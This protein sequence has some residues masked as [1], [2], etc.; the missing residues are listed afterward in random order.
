[1]RIYRALLDEPQLPHEELAIRTGCSSDQVASSLDRLRELKLLIPRWTGGAEYAVHPNLGLSILGQDRRRQLD[2]LTEELHQDELQAELIT[3][4]YNESMRHRDA[5]DIEIIEGNERAHQRM[6]E[7]RPTKSLWGFTISTSAG[8]GS[9]EDSPDRP[10]LELQLDYRVIQLTAVLGAKKHL[11]YFRWMHGY[12]AQIRTSPSL[13]MKMVIFDGAALVLPIDPDD[14]SAGLIVHHG[15]AVVTMAR[16]MFEHYWQHSTDVFAPEPGS[17][18]DLSP[19]EA[20]FLNLL[21]Q[22]ATDEQVGRKLGVSLRT[23]RRMAAKLSEQTGASGRF[24]LGVRAAQR[25]WVK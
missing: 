10:T 4:Q 22:G 8:F 5:R 18:G 19:Q 11:E 24:E 15:K 2:Q 12:G 14:H 1:L 20:E 25:G 16:A 3:Q 13:P 21:V 23:V 6:G 7:F 9:P 17:P